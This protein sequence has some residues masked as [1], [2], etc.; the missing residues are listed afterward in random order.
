MKTEL[1]LRHLRV[2]AAVM[3][4][5]TH[6]RAARALGLSQSTVSETL[7][8]LERTLGVELFRKSGKGAPALS[9]S[10]EVLLGYARRMF[11][12]S[13][14]LVGALADA[15]NGVKATL[16]VSAVESI[17]AY[18][19]P[20]RLAALRLR[21]PSVR[22]EVLTGSCGE[23]RERVASGESD[24]GL[25]LEPET[26]PEAGAIL[27]KARLLILGA[28]T[29]PL[30]RGTTA[31]NDLRR[32]DFY[33]CD[34]GGNY[35]QTLR[36]H[37]EAAGVEP[38]RMQAMGTIEGVKRGILTGGAALGL[39]PEHAVE[40]ELRE[41]VLAEIRVSPA[42]PCVVLRAV[43]A[44]GARSPVVDDLIDALRGSP[45]RGLQL[46]APAKA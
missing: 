8:A 4:A 17:G 5:G 34:A 22:V 3:E 30:A 44:P 11:A 18:V 35:H 12:L 6:T 28:P 38:P 21:W 40:S 1:E 41:N 29:H 9:P 36:Q 33:M 16:G 7:S 32:H 39:L 15:S 24:L 37:F 43:L 20:Q 10:G 27:A 14:D 26:G 19:L 2:F 42:L 46:T 25:V 45:Q 23:I 31:V 13:S